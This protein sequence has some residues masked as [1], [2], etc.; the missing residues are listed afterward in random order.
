MHPAIS[1][2]QSS[3]TDTGLIGQGQRLGLHVLGNAMSPPGRR[4][5]PAEKR[6][7]RAC[8]LVGEDTRLPL[9]SGEIAEVHERA[10][11]VP[12]CR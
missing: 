6:R 2:A 10:Q 4:I 7:G 8:G 3:Q 1:Q 11:R 12:R 5:L 9:V